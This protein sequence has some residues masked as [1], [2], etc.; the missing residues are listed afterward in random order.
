VYD[1]DAVIA[2]SVVPEM[3]FTATMP[4]T[5][6]PS[7]M[8]ADTAIATMVA[9]A[10]PGLEASAVTLKFAAPSW[11]MFVDS[12]IAFCDLS[13]LLMATAAPMPAPEFGMAL[14]L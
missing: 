13:I 12:T 1:D 6:M 2:A 7:E 5:P 11:R 4:L 14:L 10:G 8:P 3:L 9:L